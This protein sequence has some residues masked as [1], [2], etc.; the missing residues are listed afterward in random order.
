MEW[1]SFNL[2][3]SLT[4]NLQKVFA[5]P[6]EIQQKVLTYTTANVDLL[7]QARTG[8]GKTL[9]YVLPIMN[10]ILTLYERSFASLKNVSPVALVLVP[11]RELGVQVKQHIEQVIFDDS[12]SNNGVKRNLF[13]VRVAAVL[14][15]LAK[16]KQV[17]QLSKNPEI[18]VATPGRLWELIENEES[19]L[20]MH[21]MRRLKFLVIDEADRMTESGHFAE[22]KNIIEYVY[23]SVEIK[24]GDE[25]E[26]DTKK[27]KK[28]KDKEEIM[29][30]G[31]NE[32][33]D[34]EENT[35]LAKML[36][37]DVEDIET[38]DP[39]ELMD[40]N[41]FDDEE[42][43]IEEEEEEDKED[44]NGNNND[45]DSES[46]NDDDDD[47]VINVNKIKHD[48]RTTSMHKV[49]YVNKVNIRTILCSATIDLVHKQQQ[50]QRSSKKR[51]NKTQQQ[52]DESK[53]SQHFQ[54][55]IKH[56][57]FYNKLIYIKLKNA[58]DL[59]QDTPSSST[60]LPTP[61]STPLL[62]PS[63]LTLDCY[64]CTSLNK[65][66]YLYY[67]LK[68]HINSKIIVFTNSISHTKKLFSIFSYFSE[69]KPTC[70]HS[71]MLQSSRL[72]NIERFTNNETPI[73]FCTDIGA[74]G[75]DFPKVD[76]V[77]HYHL[78]RRT[79]TFI[80][81]SGRTAR[82]SMKGAVSSLISEK[83]LQLYKKIM[84][85]LDYKEFAMK[86]LSVVQLEK[87]KSLFEFAKEIEKESFRIKKANREKQWYH[88]QAQL[89]EMIYDDDNE[90]DDYDKEEAMKEKILGK[91][92]KM[93]SKEKFHKK[94][95]YTKLNE[96]NIKRSS[97][98][99]P[100]QVTKLNALMKDENMR[101][102]N[103]TQA[104]YE[105][106]NDARAIRFKDKPKR[107]RY[108]HRRKGK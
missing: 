67:L 36:N 53:A 25:G 108:M 103:L 76:L 2:N 56:L 93:L 19:E 34:I 96:S 38:I 84:I 69:F 31:K 74:R 1:S 6:T 54:H 11:T 35:K 28:I 101:K 70:L 44:N 10:Y 22:L 68:E 58:C 16:E 59:T 48:K 32:E 49:E 105:A 52:T 42:E 92:R 21:Q 66:Y 94:K 88:K 87:I 61:S 24:R 57:K 4:A 62:L 63:K 13:G 65:D 90:D 5:R 47:N 33:E 82:A 75:L 83:E 51:N 98:L 86:S 26:D 80:H 89:C 73:L 45:S 64:K 9:C 106:H 20:L 99:T 77:I 8:E 46:S 79:E 17:K 14:G 107:R 39:V 100:E 97:F 78:P 85:D 81:R 104:L 15:G 7:I 50:N 37:V 40:E 27:K 29:K 23:N 95:I 71:K 91:K 43:V 30:K 72:K 55:L 102:E 41:A 60:S 18:I 3:A 12:G